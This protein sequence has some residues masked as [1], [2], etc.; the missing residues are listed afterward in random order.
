MSAEAAR[1]VDR[2]RR[3]AVETSVLSRSPSP[4]ALATRRRR[5][6]L[7]DPQ[8][9]FRSGEVR[10]VDG[11]SLDV[12]R[13]ETVALVGESGSGKT[14]LGRVSLRL[15]QPT[16]GRVVFD[17]TTSPTCRTSDLRWF[18]QRAQIVF[19][20]PFSSLN[21]YMRVR[22]LVEEPLVIDGV[23][24]AT[25]RLRAGRA[26]A[27]GGRAGAGGALRREV[28]DD[29]VG[30]AAAAGRHRPGAGARPG[31]HRR[32]RAGLDDRRLQPDRDPR[33]AARAC[34]RRAASPSSTSP[35]TSPAPATSPTGSRS[36]TAARSSS[37]AR[38]AGDRQPAPPLHAGPDRRRPRARPA[39]PLPPPRRRPRRTE[40]AAAPS[41]P[42]C[43]FFSRC[44]TGCPA[45]ATSSAAA[46]SSTSR[47]TSW[48]ATCTEPAV[49]ARG[50]GA[51]V[52]ATVG[53]GRQPPGVLNAPGRGRST[54]R[55]KSRLSD[56]AMPSWFLE[57]RGALWTRSMDSVEG[58]GD[59]F[60][61]A[62]QVH[63]LQA[64]HL[65]KGCRSGSSIRTF[66]RSCQVG[67]W[68]V[69]IGKQVDDVSRAGSPAVKSHDR[70]SSEMRCAAY[71]G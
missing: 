22:D 14:T 67:L 29:D 45:S 56:Q 49:I 65:P 71:P 68:P 64:R 20:D 38:P 66:D 26:G 1:P 46:S 12:A 50:G 25:E 18:R 31:L 21:P 7:P 58:P 52:A 55:L 42:G 44:P 37:S 40:S 51:G 34:R 24:A 39:Q 36:C 15:M 47:G 16:G 8:G 28:P 62:G 63:G 9:F 5:G 57:S 11:V 2:A 59:G 4:S 10:A 43:P 6:R 35:T 54:S 53:R 41:P 17:G 61:Q 70:L 69:T 3:R 32:R 13:G 27:G 60:S 30:R 33:P 19:Q 48:P 23:R